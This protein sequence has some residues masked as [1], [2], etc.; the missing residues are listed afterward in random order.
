M[1]SAEQLRDAW[2]TIVAA[3]DPAV[4]FYSVAN[5]V[6]DKVDQPEAPHVR[7]RIHTSELVRNEDREY[8][9]RFNVVMGVYRITATDREA[10][11]VVTDHSLA[12]D[13]ARKLCM[14]FS[15]TYGND[16][17]NL[18]LGDPY[19]EAFVEAGT[20]NHTGVIINVDVYDDTPYCA[21]PI[22]IAPPGTACPLT[23]TVNGSEITEV[24]DPCDAPTLAL[25]V[26]DQDG[27]PVDVTFDGLAIV[28][29]MPAPS[30]LPY[31]NKA[32][33][34]AD[35]NT[36]P[37]TAQVVHVVSTRRFYPCNGTSTVS[38][39]VTGENYLIP[40]REESETLYTTVEGTEVK[41][42][43]NT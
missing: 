32:A 41:I 15:A 20:D 13:L 1:F 34:V 11:E 43:I 36:V 29:D 23:V 5:V 2:A 22:E 40:V 7:W 42:Q 27:N 31:E 39:I 33:A 26:E 9:A 14:E 21:D 3:Q 28:V 8:R 17:Y 25:T 16:T 12:L 30:I 24:A 38:E 4:A 37:T 19:F 35:T 6:R 18:R 10:D